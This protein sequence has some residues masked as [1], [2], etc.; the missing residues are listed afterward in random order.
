MKQQNIA[1]ASMILIFFNVV[2]L[3]LAK[4]YLFQSPPL[5]AQQM[6]DWRWAFAPLFYFK[7]LNKNCFL[8]LPAAQRAA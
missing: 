4:R 3:I 2:T 8:Y 1:V 7:Q 5:G 6:R